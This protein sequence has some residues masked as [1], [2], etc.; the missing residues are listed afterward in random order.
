MKTCRTEEK[1]QIWS[2]TA[3][4]NIFLTNVPKTLDGEKTTSSKNVAGKSGYLPV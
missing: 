2:H 1:T 4:P 3:L